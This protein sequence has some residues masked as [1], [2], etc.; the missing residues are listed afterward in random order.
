MKHQFK[1]SDFPFAKF[2]IETSIWTMSSKLF[3]NNAELKRSRDQKDAYLIPRGDGSLALA[4]AKKRYIDL[5][6]VIEVDGELNHIFNTLKWYNFLVAVFPLVLIFVGGV[7]GGIIGLLATL[8]NLSVFYQDG[9][10]ILK[11]LEVAI[12]TIISSLIYGL[13]VMLITFFIN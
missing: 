8:K 9:N 7:L 1:L 3:M 6:P 2:E 4:Y 13:L 5:V 10:V 12:T 11:Y